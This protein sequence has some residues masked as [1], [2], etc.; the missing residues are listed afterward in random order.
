MYFNF[1][2]NGKTW[3]ICWHCRAEEYILLPESIEKIYLFEELGEELPVEKSQDGVI[4]SAGSRKY[5]EFDLN[6][7][8]VINIFRET[9]IL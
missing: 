2:R 6:K 9:K 3:V 1:I 4:I 7:E 5:L 8:Q